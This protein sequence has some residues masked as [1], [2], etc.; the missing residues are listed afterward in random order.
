MPI[1]Q[2]KEKQRRE[3]RREREKEKREREEREKS[4]ETKKKT[5]RSKKRDEWQIKKTEVVRIQQQS[6]YTSECI[7]KMNGFNS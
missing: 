5:K 4:S 7:F 6:Q 2:K 3:S 1:H